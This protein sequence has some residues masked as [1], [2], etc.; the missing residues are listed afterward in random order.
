MLPAIQS[1]AGDIFQQDNALDHH[2]REAIY[3]L[4]PALPISSLPI[5]GRQTVEP[6][7]PQNLEQHAAAGIKDSRQ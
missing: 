1:V 4:D 7:W 5:C 2:A 3:L 6:S